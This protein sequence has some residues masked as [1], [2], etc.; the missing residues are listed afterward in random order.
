F[1]A[2]E[3]HGVAEMMEFN[4]LVQ[5]KAITFD[6]RY[7]VDESKMP[8]AIAKLAQE[9]L[10]IEASGDRTRAESWFKKYGAMPAELKTA[11][12][13]AQDAPVDVDPIFSFPELR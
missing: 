2:G 8:A 6:T 10:E 4:F 3:A 9:L 5:E 1:G 7:V 12:Q 13:A 11:L